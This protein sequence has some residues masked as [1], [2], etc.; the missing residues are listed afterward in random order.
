MTSKAWWQT[1]D[2]LRINITKIA[3][4]VLRVSQEKT[5]LKE[6]SELVCAMLNYTYSTKKV[7]VEY[8]PLTVTASSS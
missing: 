3:V 6:L 7:P 5:Q 1:H 4:I 8:D 2:F